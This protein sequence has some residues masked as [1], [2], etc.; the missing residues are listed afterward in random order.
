MKNYSLEEMEDLSRKR[1]IY[2]IDNYCDGNR[3]ELAR[4]TGIG[5]SSI[6]QYVNGTNTPGNITAAKIGYEFGIDPMWIMGFDVPMDKK[7]ADKYRQKESFK[8]DLEDHYNL[9]LSDDDLEFIDLYCKLP[10][11]KKQLFLKIAKSV[12]E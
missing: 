11:D 5:K 1:I 8:Q 9:E 6:S 7:E 3:M 12:L 4:R 2:I 10:E